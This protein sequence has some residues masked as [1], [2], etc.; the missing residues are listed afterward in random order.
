LALKAEK[1]PETGKV[2]VCL[3]FAFFIYYWTLAFFEFF[4]GRGG[5]GA[6]TG[7]RTAPRLKL[8]FRQTPVYYLKWS[9]HAFKR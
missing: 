1:R 5:H 7:A 3:T 8:N 2:D 9:H 4:S 6:G